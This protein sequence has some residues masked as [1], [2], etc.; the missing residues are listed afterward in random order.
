VVRPLYGS[1]C[2]IGLKG[3]HQI[4]C[5][6]QFHLKMETELPSEVSYSVRSQNDEQSP[7][8][9]EDGFTKYFYSFI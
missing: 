8:E 2:I 5:C 4:S 6:F 7:N 1:L 3:E 9:E